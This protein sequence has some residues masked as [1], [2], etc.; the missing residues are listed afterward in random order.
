MV[1]LPSPERP[2]LSSTPPR[3]HVVAEV[4]CLLCARLV[5]TVIADRWPP[6]GPV[7]FQPAGASSAHILAAWWRLRCSVCGGNTA[8]SE[9]LSRIPEPEAAP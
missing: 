8:A 9:F 7:R 1:L 3:R 5:G 6:G 2:R 4:T